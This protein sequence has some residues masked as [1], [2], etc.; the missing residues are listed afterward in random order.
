M[1]GCGVPSFYFR[2][3]N[4]LFEL[5]MRRSA[6]ILLFLFGLVLVH[7]QLS[8]AQFAETDASTDAPAVAPTPTSTPVQVD[9]DHASFAFDANTSLVELYLAFEA[10]TLSYEAIEGGFLAVLPVNMAIVRSTQVALN[11]TPMDPVWKDSL[12]LSF[13]VADTTGLVEGQHFVHQ[14]RTAVSP[15]EYELQVSIPAEVAGQDSDLTIRRDVLVPDFSNQDQ[16]R[17]SDVTLASQITPSQD[18]EDAFYKNGMVIRPNANQLYGSGLNRLFYYAE[19]YNLDAVSASS[20]KYTVF[21]YIAEANVPQPIQGKQRRTERPLRS[22]DVLAASFSVNDL[23]SGSYFLRIAILNDNNQAMA[24][25]SRKFFVYNP[26]VA[27][28]QP[29]A[30]ETDFESSQYANMTEEEVDRMEAHVRVIASETEFRRLRSIRDLDEKRRF[31][32]DFWTT[33]DPNPNTP[34]NEFQEGFYALVQYANDRY[35]TRSDEG[36][37][38]DRGRTLLKYSTP[39]A[40][41]PHLFDRG[42]APYEV[43]EYNNIP[44][45]GQAIF[46]FADL[47]G[48]GVFE[49]IHSSVTGERQLADWQNELRR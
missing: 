30:V 1:R 16:V 11:D 19:V 3:E 46:V 32:M 26:E 48:F 38:T 28:E 27:R 41:E 22:P 37:N 17:V 21:S 7:P 34:I 42:Y 49:L 33:R 9:I 47:D 6:T 15:G 40:I 8:I 43:W 45:E 44:G 13:M 39:T 25:Q 4:H 2:I 20:E 5:L 12:S 35:T 24:E 14:L 29:V 36:W 23:P 31:F 10:S 18:R